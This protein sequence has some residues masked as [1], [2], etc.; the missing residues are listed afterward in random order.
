MPA[1]GLSEKALNENGSPSVRG[2][3]GW[4]GSRNESDNAHSGGKESGLPEISGATSKHP[5]W[6]QTGNY[7]TQA[8]F[9]IANSAKLEFH[10]SHE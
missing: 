6:R 3:G 4:L 5:D 8:R 9:P 7:E 10:R 1:L 2:N